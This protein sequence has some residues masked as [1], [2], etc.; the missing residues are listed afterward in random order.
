MKETQMSESKTQLLRLAKRFPSQLIKTIKKGNRE[1]DYI[2]HSVIAQRLLQVLGPYSWDWEIVYEEGKVVA[3]H[4][5]LTV[6]VDGKEVTVSGAGTETYSNDSTGE[7]IKKMESDAFKRAAAKL[8]SGLH[9]WSQEQYFLDVQLAKD[10]G[11]NLEE[12]S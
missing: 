6:T 7:K 4:G 5:R 3:L 10:L 12:I 2:N 8:G 9:L 1:E 11:I